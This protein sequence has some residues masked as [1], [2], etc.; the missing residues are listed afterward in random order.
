LIKQ[1]RISFILILW[2]SIAL[3]ICLVIIWSTY[4]GFSFVKPKTHNSDLVEIRVQPESLKPEPDPDLI[5]DSN[6]VPASLDAPAA[7]TAEEWQIAST[8]TLK[9]SKRYRYNWGQQVRSMMGTAVEGKDQGLVR[10]LIEIAP[11][12]KIAKVDTLWKTSDRAEQLARKAIQAMPPLPPTPTGKPL[13]FEKTISFLPYETGW[14]PTYKYDC[15][16]DPPSS[17]N[18]FAWDGKSSQNK[19]VGV[20]KPPVTEEELRAQRECV[21]NAAPD[22]LDA[23][24]GN[25][26][27]QFEQWRSN[28]LND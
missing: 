23:Y 11:N 18:P 16:P 22:S 4:E 1:K 12:G 20:V 14:P 7:P 5:R 24:S 26:Q 25:M 28:K 10:F 2:A 21:K 6:L 13:I 3:H 19:Q 15:L 8:Y 9:N 27:R 17:G